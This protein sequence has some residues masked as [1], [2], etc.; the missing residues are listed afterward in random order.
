MTSTNI[1][2]YSVEPCRVAELV[3]PNVFGTSTSAS[4]S[5]IN[6]LPPVGDHQLWVDSLYL[7]GLPLA[8]AL[9]ALG[10]RGQPWRAW[11]A[12]VAVLGLA[13][14]LGKYASPLWW[15]RSGPLASF[16]GPH[17]LPFGQP[18][19][20]RHLSDGAGSPYAILSSLLPGFGSFRFPSKLLPLAMAALTA[21]AGAGWD[22]VTAGRGERR[23]L[24][25]ALAGLSSS[26]LGLVLA[27]TFKSHAVA[28]LTSRLPADALF[29][30]VDVAA[31][32]TGTQWA[33]AH[34]ALIFAATVAVARLGPRRPILCGAGALLLLNVDLTLANARL[35]ETVSQAELDTPPEALRLIEAAERSDPSPSPFRIHRMPGWFPR[36]FATARDPQRSRDLYAWSRDTLSPLIALPYRLNYCTTSGSFE[37]EEDLE[38]FRPRMIPLVAEMARTLGVPAGQ[39]VVYYPRRS[40]DLWGTRY[41]LLPASPDWKS[42]SRGFLSFLD[43]TDLI[44]PS[45]EVVQERGEEGR[46]S[47][48]MRED[49]QLR[50]IRRSFHG[51]GSFTGPGFLPPPPHPRSAPVSSVR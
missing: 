42:P 14:S 22:D 36:R 5:W 47:W 2:R 44:Y 30:P 40:F 24:R 6:A 3:W 49:W 33:L 15:A 9:V 37:L 41:F 17:D 21:L 32:W 8:L 28:W 31:A 27:L 38:L 26:L 50:A 7:G 23:L 25:L 20:D 45:L 39:P 51:P 10:V 4:G 11:L 46:D 12:A 35:I 48:S 43:Q 29:G 19:F 1:Y 18:R 13:A 34:G 16:V